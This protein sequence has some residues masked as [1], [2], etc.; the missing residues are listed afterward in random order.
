[1]HCRASQRGH[2]GISADASW[3]QIEGAS[4]FQ[5]L[6]R[7]LMDRARVR[8]GGHVKDLIIARCSFE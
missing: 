1:M 7:T 6:A 4:G 8:S 2:R 5:H 3:R